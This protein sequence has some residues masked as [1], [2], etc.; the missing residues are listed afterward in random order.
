MAM[1]DAFQVDK[2]DKK[3]FQILK[4]PCLPVDIIDWSWSTNT[5]PKRE[6]HSVWE[7]LE[8]V[9]AIIKP[10]EIEEIDGVLET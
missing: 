3:Y 8:E 9:E 5:C 7:G 1:L 4:N 6:Y 10:G 2:V